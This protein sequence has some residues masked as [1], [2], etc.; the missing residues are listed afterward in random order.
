LSASI[1]RHAAR[2]S[3][4]HPRLSISSSTIRSAL[5]PSPAFPPRCDV[6]P[7]RP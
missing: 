7:Y 1:L 6:R 2:S 5:R 3:S 4:N